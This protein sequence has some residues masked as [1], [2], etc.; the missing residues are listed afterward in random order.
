MYTAEEKLA[1]VKR[2]LAMRHRVYPS[3]VDKGRMTSEKAAHEI[4]V[5]EAIVRDYERDV[6]VSRKQLKM[7]I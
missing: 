5:M 1:C 6:E 2:E 7:S 3:W 4:A